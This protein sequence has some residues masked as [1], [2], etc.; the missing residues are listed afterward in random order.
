MLATKEYIDAFREAM[1]GNP[2]S[3]AVVSN[4]E[5]LTVRVPKP[6]DG[7]TR[8]VWQFCT[9]DL[10]IAFGVD[11]ETKGEDGAVTSETVLPI[12][13]INANT[14]VVTGSHTATTAG[15]WLLRFDNSYS[16]FRSKTIF[17]R[18]VCYNI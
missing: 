7:S 8:I 4:G 6:F 12:M 15:T 18:V 11:F 5:V 10:D 1:Q 16:Y 2:D 14:Q 3:E 13:R 17:Y 9:E